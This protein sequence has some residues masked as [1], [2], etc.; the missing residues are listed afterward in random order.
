[1]H[2]E[3]ALPGQ[4]QRERDVKKAK[5]VAESAHECYQHERVLR[6]EQQRGRCSVKLRSGK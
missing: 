2:R 6:S 4:G 5:S 3:S 1:M